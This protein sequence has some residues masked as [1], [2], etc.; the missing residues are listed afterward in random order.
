MAKVTARVA[1]ML[2]NS[3]P[4]SGLKVAPANS[5]PKRGAF[6][7]LLAVSRLSCD[8]E[9]AWR[10]RVR[11]RMKLSAGPSSQS[12]IVPRSLRA[13]MLSGSSSVVVPGDWYSHV[14]RLR[15]GSYDQTCPA[16]LP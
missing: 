15:R 9:Q 8:V 16:P 11:P 13:V 6:G 10:Q 4:P 1:W 5:S 3:V 2:T 12:T 7:G 14:R